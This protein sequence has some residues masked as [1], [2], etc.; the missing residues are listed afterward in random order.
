MIKQLKKDM[1]VIQAA[2]ETIKSTVNELRCNKLR[3]IRSL[4]NLILS[5]PDNPNIQRLSKRCFAMS[6]SH[7]SLRNWT[8]EYYD[9]KRQYRLICREV[10]VRRIEKILPFLEKIIQNGFL[11]RE[12]FIYAG[13]K[14]YKGTSRFTFH[15]EVITYL[16]TIFKSPEDEKSIFIQ[17]ESTALAG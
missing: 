7:L 5:L 4:R 8:P 17:T 6:F 14:G 12:E 13:H 11:I 16:K 9:F 3:I 1:K 2:E 10:L 15:P